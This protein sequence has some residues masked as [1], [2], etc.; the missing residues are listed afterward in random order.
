MKKIGLVIAD[1]MLIEMKVKVAKN[2][3]LK[4]NNTGDVRY[5]TVHIRFRTLNRNTCKINVLICNI[6]ISLAL[7]LKFIKAT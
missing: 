5:R 1:R 4:E 2:N 3:F 7:H 6:L